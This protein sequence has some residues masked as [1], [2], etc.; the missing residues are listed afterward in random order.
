MQLGV[1]AALTAG[2]IV[3]SGDQQAGLI[4]VYPFFLGIPGIAVILLVFLPFE[5]IAIRYD[6]RW[7]ALLLHPALGAAVPWI[8]YPLAGNT[9]NFLS[10]MQMLTPLGFVWGLLWSATGAVYVGLRRSA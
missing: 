4:L 10:A 5:A 1:V 8:L 7:L 3:L 6:K 9:G 2:F